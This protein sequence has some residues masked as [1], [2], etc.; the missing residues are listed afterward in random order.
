[1][2]ASDDIYQLKITLDD[3]RPPVWRR[4][5]LP[6]NATFRDLHETIQ[7]SFGW[8][9]YHLHDFQV[10]RS[11][12]PRLHSI[13]DLSAEDIEPWWDDDKKSDERRVKVCD[14]FREAGDRCR[15]W[16]DFGDDWW[17]S[18]VLEKI[19]PAIQGIEYP[20]CIKGKR[21]C[22]PEDCGGPWGYAELCEILTQPSHPEH[23]DKLDWLGLNDAS[24]FDP[25]DFDINTI[26]EL[27]RD[28][29]E[30]CA[31]VTTM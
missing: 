11:G 16:Y 4:I 7:L 6:A 15:Y 14:F 9:D 22:P 3:T 25:E 1:M 20:V 13:T 29:Y 8:S 24:E 21:A 12:V 31:S 23:Q 28:G 27:L 2:R 18:I 17:H 5:L 26:N 10:G 30:A 19:L